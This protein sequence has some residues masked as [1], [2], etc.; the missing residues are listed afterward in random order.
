VVY[1]AGHFSPPNLEALRKDRKQYPYVK[2]FAG[3]SRDTIFGEAWAIHKY[4]AW[5]DSMHLRYGYEFT[6][7]G[8]RSLAKML[9]YV[10][11]HELGFTEWGAMLVR[12]DLEL[13]IKHYHTFKKHPNAQTAMIAYALEH[14]PE[15]TM[16]RGPW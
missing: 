10:C 14:G 11:I 13:H 9:E 7:E 1:P 5:H 15:L 16:Q 3:G 4:R 12:F 6:E 8:E 2:V